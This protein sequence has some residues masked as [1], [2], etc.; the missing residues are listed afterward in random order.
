M[1]A[2]VDEEVS[3]CAC[4]YYYSQRFQIPPMIFIDDS[5]NSPF[6]LSMIFYCRCMVANSSLTPHVRGFLK[7]G[8]NV[9]NHTSRFIRSNSSSQLKFEFPKFDYDK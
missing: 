8:L 7:R 6:R 3:C 5:I 9:F 1:F 2:Q 4:L